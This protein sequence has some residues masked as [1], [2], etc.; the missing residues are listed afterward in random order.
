MSQLA[1]S[2]SFEYLGYVISLRS[3]YVYVSILPGLA[4]ALKGLIFTTVFI[5]CEHIESEY[6]KL[7]T[8]CQFLYMFD[9]QNTILQFG[10]TRKFCS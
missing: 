4:P 10:K 7:L 8:Y 1:L 2:A 3:L 6:I 5:Q 9:I